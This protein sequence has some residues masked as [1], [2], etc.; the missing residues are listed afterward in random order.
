[1]TDDYDDAELGPYSTLRVSSQTFLSFFLFWRPFSLAY[2]SH[3][4][5]GRALGTGFSLGNLENVKNYTNDH[6]K[7][8]EKPGSFIQKCIEQKHYHTKML[9]IAV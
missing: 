6:G 1:M 9:G 5:G 8:D 7:I 3:L 4:V 2:F